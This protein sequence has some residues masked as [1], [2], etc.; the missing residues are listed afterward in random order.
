M[1][2][3]LL[4]W[5]SSYLSNR[6][7]TVKIDG[8]TSNAFT[9]TSGIPQG[10]HLGPLLFILFINDISDV[11]TSAE[12]LIYAGDLKLFHHIDSNYDRYLLQ[13]D[14]D[15]VVE[16]SNCNRL[17]LNNNKSK[18]ITFSRGCVYSCA[19]NYSIEGTILEKVDSI[20]D[21]G[22]IYQY[23]FHFDFFILFIEQSTG[24]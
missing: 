23:N 8:I 1:R 17:Y 5:L 16:W 18:I 15:N 20:R 7:H 12:F 4:L 22:I 10:S 24:D 9:T 3:G 6:Q 19:I 21:L 2:G 11:I 14:L 13:I